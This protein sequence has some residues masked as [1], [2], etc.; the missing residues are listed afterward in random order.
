MSERQE[1]YKQSMNQGHSAAWDLEWDRAALYYQQAL[2]EIADDPKALANLALAWFK[3]EDYKKS[4]KYYILAAKS[5]PKDPVPLEKAA[6]L[7]YKLDQGKNASQFAARA[8]ASY[9]E[10]K[11]SDKA[12][13]NW[14]RAISYNSENLNAHAR[15]AVVYERLG[16][17]PQATREYLSIASL[18]L[19]S[20]QREK[21]FHAVD[22][23]LKILPNSKEA[24]QSLNMLREGTM[25]P[26]PE[27]PKGTTGLLAEL[28]E[29]P[30]S[31]IEVPTEPIDSDLN[32]ID[33]AYHTALSNLAS[34]FF[35]QSSDDADTDSD[36]KHNL[37]AIVDG[38]AG[39]DFTKNADQIKI[40]QHLGQ[41]VEL[42]TYGKDAQAAE[43]LK[44]AIEV[45][46]DAPSAH[47][48]LG[49]LF[50][51]IQRLESAVRH[52]QRVTSHPDYALGAYLLLGNISYQF[53]KHTQAAVRYLEA[54]RTADSMI[55]SPELAD[56]LL[57]LYDPLIELQSRQKDKNQN[58]QLSENVSEL[59]VRPNWRQH[60]KETRRE[61]GGHENGAHPT[62]LAEILIETSSSAIV[63]ALSSV[64]RLVR[65]GHLGAALDQILYTLEHAPTYLPL[66]IVLGEVL[67]SKDCLPE[68]VQ[69]FKVVAH[70]YS[71]RGEGRRAVTMQKRVIE[72]APM[73]MAV[74]RQLVEQLM[75]N[76]QVDEAINE[77]IQR[78]EIHYNLAELAEARDGYSYA[79]KLAK[80]A[81]NPTRWLVRILHRIATIDRQSLN[82]RE[83]MEI[84]NRI[85]TLAPNDV[86]AYSN[87]I[88]LSFRLGEPDQAMKSTDQFVIY[89]NKH[90]QP[91]NAL[92]LLIKLAEEQADQPMIFHRLANQ[93][94]RMELI[95]DAIEQLDKAAKLL[96]N[97]GEKTGARTLI[98]QI[99]KLD[100]Q[101]KQAYQ[102][103]LQTL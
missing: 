88:D 80:K 49:L 42:Q 26:K 28:K 56:E 74:R 100:P 55:V 5:N 9:F 27:R 14:L 40:M 77:N 92:A 52:L 97:E 66:H 22:R 58:M 62:P 18:M 99:V 95:P 13:E 63:A 60:L 72:M 7:Y 94:Q 78:A 70:A 83:A 98:Q 23:A 34:L 4:L 36:A 11:N 82:W 90:Q 15:L 89:A 46:L 47:F 39:P 102:K 20:G 3:L 64:R 2:D 48:S 96:I 21:A 54:L 1:R 73:D 84:Y 51:K 53:E 41:A 69:K 17:K 45:G 12:V 68:A 43:E 38:S 86:K 19:H 61:L 59:L 29:K 57:E 31:Q 24:L 75:A 37:Q 79:L 93:Y 6:T 25:L 76:G 44:G 35:E 33:E 101:N 81:D 16:H 87:L 30:A 8:A 32:P 91:D 71:I 65:E 85:C 50:V 67:I 103:L 10:E